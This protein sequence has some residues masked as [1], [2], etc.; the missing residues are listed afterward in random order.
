MEEE[1]RLVR[2]VYGKQE[3]S[4][5]YFKR[6]AVCD[7]LSLYMP[8]TYT[9]MGAGL[10]LFLHK[11][12]PGEKYVLPFANKIPDSINKKFRPLAY[13]VP[14][15]TDTFMWSPFHDA[16]ST[17]WGLGDGVRHAYRFKGQLLRDLKVARQLKRPNLIIVRKH[18]EQM[19]KKVSRIWPEAK[20]ILVFYDDSRLISCPAKKRLRQYRKVAKKTLDWPIVK[21]ELTE[22]DPQNKADEQ[23]KKNL[24]LGWEH[25]CPETR[26]LFYKNIREV[27]AN[28]IKRSI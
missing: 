20:K 17:F 2:V 16:L 4:L 23:N 13:K 12:K 18:I 25:Y 15:K 8:G 28:Y 7:C 1:E 19:D 3:S 26:E 14:T 27:E 21:V 6:F 11:F 5:E 22:G 9:A 24:W 10:E